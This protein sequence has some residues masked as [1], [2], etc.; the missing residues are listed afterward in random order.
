[1]IFWGL[2]GQKSTGSF[3]IHFKISV[4]LSLPGDPFHGLRI[5]FLP[6]EIHFYDRS[7]QILIGS[8][9]PTH[10]GGGSGNTANWWPTTWHYYKSWQ[11]NHRML[12]LFSFDFELVRLTSS[13]LNH[14]I[15]LKLSE[16]QLTSSCQKNHSYISLVL[17][18]LSQRST[19]P[20]LLG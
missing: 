7:W 3:G 4:S 10:R 1:M 20:I 5:R 14:L 6:Q 16:I 9:D 18:N 8:V 11:L 17:M 15:N 13:L 12:F 2:V 19:Q